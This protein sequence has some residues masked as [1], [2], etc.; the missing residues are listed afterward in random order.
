MNTKI[1]SVEFSRCFKNV[2]QCKGTSSSFSALSKTRTG[3]PLNIQQ[4]KKVLMQDIIRLKLCEF[5]KRNF[6]V[7]RTLEGVAWHF[8]GVEIDNGHV[9][10]HE[11]GGRKFIRNTGV[12]TVPCLY[13]TLSLIGSVSYEWPEGDQLFGYL[14]AHYLHLI[15]ELI[16]W[17]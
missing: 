6:S 12:C 15:K 16:S 11:R 3:W 2:L 14:N 9:Y 8:T 5:K 7:M 4:A 13:S 1:F 10:D 17:K